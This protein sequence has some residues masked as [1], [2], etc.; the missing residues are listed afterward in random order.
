MQKHH[1]SFCESLPCLREQFLLAFVACNSKFLTF[2]FFSKTLWSWLFT[3]FPKSTFLQLVNVTVIPC[4]TKLLCARTHTYN[5]MHL[6]VTFL[7]K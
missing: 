3:S 1:D 5:F 7:L 2:D 4:V 6:D